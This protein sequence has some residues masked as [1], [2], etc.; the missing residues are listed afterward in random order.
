MMKLISVLFVGAVLLTGC[1]SSS[2]VKKLEDVSPCC[3]D[4]SSITYA[5]LTYK[6]G[7]TSTFG[8][9][10]S[11]ARIFPEGKSFFMPIKLPAFESPYEIQIE[12]SPSDNEIVLPR[13]LLLN[14]NY[15]VVKKVSS[16]KFHYE[17]GT[18]THKF[19]INK[20][21]GYRYMILYTSP[22]DTGKESV[23]LAGYGHTTAIAAGPYLFNYTA[24]VD[25][26][27]TV[28]SS[29]RGDVAVK[30]LQYKPRTL[31]KPED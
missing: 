8:G 30:A 25:T 9:K 28:K 27:A 16:T 20:E 24:G 21:L 6:K 5:N 31:E 12:S 15:Q 4:L 13:I 17:N 2:L 1:A 7:V 18:A 11:Q 3:S 14:Q 22:R 10:D 23:A 19:F 26:K 29:S